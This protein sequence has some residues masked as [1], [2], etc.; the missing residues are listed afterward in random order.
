MLQFPNMLSR[1]ILRS[2]KKNQNTIKVVAGQPDISSKARLRGR[3][4]LGGY[5]VGSN[6]L[7]WHE[8]RKFP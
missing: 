2:D 7:E 8:L 4:N 6:L 5:N 1:P 3:V